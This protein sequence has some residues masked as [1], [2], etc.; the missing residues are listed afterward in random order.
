MMVHD[1]EEVGE[2][3]E[4]P[5]DPHYTP[6]IIQPST[7]Q[8]QK[9]QRS[10]RSK[11]KDTEVPQPSGPTT[12]VADEAVN[13]E[14][15]D[16]L[17]RAATTATSLD[18]E[19]DRGNINKTRSK[20][21]LNEPSSSGTSSGSGPRRQ[22]T[23]GDTIAQTRSENVSKL[24]N[25]P[26]LAREDASKQGRIADIDA[27]KD[28]YLVNVWTDED[29]FGVNDLGGDEVIVESVDVV[30]TAKETRNVVEEV[31][32]VTIPVSAATTTTTAITDVEM[33]LAQALAE[34]KSAKPKA[35][36]ITT[37][38]ILTT[39]TAATTITVVSTRPKVKG[40]VFH[41]Q[42]QAPTPI[43]SSQQPS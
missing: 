27:N 32:A 16:S 29:M 5:T 4:M 17:E 30:K 11:R 12:N 26:L 39:T 43:V 22:E 36:T 2:G 40:I 9:K 35:T 42:E 34:S 25:D 31:T 10:R 33:T 13:E 24:S 38:S 23:M 28:I 14:M 21:T 41:D 20:A 18:A 6:T 7:S 15:D 19:Q 3:S 8:P 37:T 1:Q